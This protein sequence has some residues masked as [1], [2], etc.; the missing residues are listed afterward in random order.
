MFAVFCLAMGVF[1]LFFVP[2]TKQRTLEEIDVIFGA[3]DAETRHRDVEG[4]L[5]GKKEE[6]EDQPTGEHVGDARA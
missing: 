1:V 5:A 4:V 2:E 6:E 3:V